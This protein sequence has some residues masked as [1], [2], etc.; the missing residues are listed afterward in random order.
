MIVQEHV[1]AKRSIL[2]FTNAPSTPSPEPN[3]T[4]PN[5]PSTTE[6]V[7]TRVNTILIPH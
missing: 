6:P 7:S 4:T 5:A 3:S 1:D 2:R